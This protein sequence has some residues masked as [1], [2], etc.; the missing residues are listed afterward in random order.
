MQQRD[1]RIRQLIE[2]Y[3]WSVRKV[4]NAV[5][6]D[7]SSVS[8]INRG[9]QNKSGTGKRGASTDTK[10]ASTTPHALPPKQFIRT[11]ENLRLTLE[12]PEGRA[13]ALAAL[14]DP[15]RPVEVT[16]R[17]MATLA[18]VADTLQELV[19]GPKAVRAGAA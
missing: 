7:P 9:K 4:A 2:V 3:N 12:K 19:S 1:S 8:R 16:Q 18:F 10:G 15:K 6:L 5:G 14:Y 11:L 13:L 17:I